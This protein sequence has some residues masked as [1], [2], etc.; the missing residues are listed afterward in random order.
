MKDFLSTLDGMFDELFRTMDSGDS[1]IKCGYCK[2]D[3]YF[4]RDYFKLHLLSV[5]LFD[6]K[7][8]QYHT[9]GDI[10]EVLR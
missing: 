8:T 5:H 1:L 7:R 6:S 4:H 3:V 9:S 2:P 10:P